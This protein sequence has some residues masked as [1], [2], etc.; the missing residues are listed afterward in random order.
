MKKYILHVVIL[1]CL[2]LAKEAKGQLTHYFAEEFPVTF[3][4]L[5]TWLLEDEVDSVLLTS[6][7]LLKKETDSRIK[8]IVHFYRGEV[9]LLIGQEE[10]GNKSLDEAIRLFQEKKYE[11]GLAIVYS[12]KADLL[13]GNGELEKGRRL[14]HQSIVFAKQEK[15]NEVLIDVYQKL[16]LTFATSQTP[17]SAISLLKLAL[18]YASQD[19]E[20]SNNIINQISTNYHALGQLDSAI[21]YF[22]RG[23]VLKQQLDDPDGL[24]SDHSALGNLYRERGD[25]E[26]AQEQLMEALNIAERTD[27]S[28]AMMT[29]Y[30]ELGDIY[31]AQQIW[32]VSENYYNQSLELARQKNS[33]FRE[34][35]CFKKLGR[36][37]QL[38]QKDSAAVASFQAALAIYNQ[39]KN[40]RNAAEI[41]ISLSQIYQNDSQFQKAKEL[42]EEALATRGSQDMM[43][44]LPIR[45][46]LAD[47][48]IKLGNHQTGIE[49][50]KAC[51]EAFEKMGDKAGMRQAYLLLSDAYSQA[52]NYKQA[53]QYHQAYSTINDSLVSVERAEAI[54]KYDLLLTT[55]KKDAEI[56]RQDEQIK[57]QGI[58]LLK[59]NN[60][61]LLLAGG[62]GFI[63]LI[64]GLLFFVYYKNKQL[65]QQRIQVL[66]KEQETQRLKAII[67]G[68]E[69]ERK[70]LAREL[71][72]GLGAVLATVKMQISGIQRKFPTVQTSETYQKAESLIDDACRT[73]RE[74]SHDLMPY[75]L[76]QQGLFSAIDEICQNLS[77]QHDT[78][79]DF[80]SFG[81]EA[82][83]NDVLTI[84][85]YRITQ[86]LL[87][88][89]LKHAEATEVIV[90]LTI[91]DEEIMLIVE[92]DGKGFDT[93]L[94]KKG[95]GLDNIYS[96]A[97][98]LNGKLEIDSTIGQGST[99]TI[100]LP[101]PQNKA[102]DD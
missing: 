82:Q 3:S 57:N 74:V 4:S 100:L 98:Y 29:I 24:I 2:L 56:S 94:Q 22:Q 37:F 1:I 78:S 88:N 26:Q 89:I 30:S 59:R 102:T 61:I 23:L 20:Q 85:L 62:L 9:E 69:K 81:D 31:A 12:R 45:L 79:F 35:G 101:K 39:L 67:E 53:F 52:G 8:G 33:R 49:Y 84:T 95:I 54:K 93:S 63:A 44:I 97:A 75:V 28:F 80:I 5:E 46:A 42:L 11:K 50:A 99:F 76:E 48:E 34:A 68:E 16:A 32:N 60:Q 14:C 83:L 70:R 65:S 86:E 36:I 17:D 40:K 47:I 77:R 10:Q 38:Q 7:I 21:T 25:Y 66:E 92:D 87:K 90:Q 41:M 19:A 55:Q 51:I 27:N 18:A 73:V 13:L 6:E 91:E 72:D 15:L 64:A 71:H 58:E 43:S 96:R